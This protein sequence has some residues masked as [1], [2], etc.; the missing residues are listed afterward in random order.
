MMSMTGIVLALVLLM[1]LAY[2][3]VSV[4]LLAPLM[5]LLA[6]LFSPEAPLLASYTQVFMPA[7][8]GFVIAFFPL[9]LLGAVFG[10]LME[11]SG[12]AQV[13][14]HAIVAWLGAQRAI[15]AVVLACAVLTYGGVSLFV[16]AFAVYPIATALFRQAD[17]P[18]RLIPATIALGAFTF[19]MTALPGT[20]AIQNAIPMPYFGTTP[21]AAP[22]L[23][24]IG[25]AVM[26]VLGTLWLVRRAGAASAR[27]EGYGEHAEPAALSDPAAAAA[28]PKAS[29]GTSASTPPNTSAHTAAAAPPPATGF[30]GT[31]FM[32]AMAPVVLV[33]A[34][35]YLLAT[36]LL[37]AL[38]TA[39]LAEPRYGAT[40]IA[41]VRGLWAVMVALAA[42]IVLL[43]LL[44]RP[45]LPDLRHTLEQGA[46]GSVLP[47][48]NTASQVGFGAVIASLAGFA[49]IR[50]AV[51]TIAPDNPL[52]SVSIAVNI[53]AGITGSAS[54][55]MSIALQTLGDTWLAMG[56]AAGIA[57]DLLHRVTAIATGG[58]D[59]LPHNGAVITLLG[60][61][62]LSHRQAYADIFMVAVAIPVLAL[63]VVV[64]LGSTFG[65][66]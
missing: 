42:A 51:L 41:N 47:L 46:S 15:L 54:G 58:L 57:P 8:G 64:V 26:L 37:P 35:N 66:F 56:Q 59:A 5:A 10:K 52:V 28:M 32:R 30:N 18:K 39:Y 22:G 34:L 3:G 40:A 12:A 61:C 29:N 31:A 11:A 44:Q 1:A 7:L 43:V 60:I 48:L 62:G 20:P 13:I 53:L 50:D 33:I 19:T 6:T 14:A 36:W 65:S 63:V 45:H 2:R 9:F 25:G 55:G 4:L 27:G 16:V 21:F 24:L 23:G 17:L 49:L 38:D